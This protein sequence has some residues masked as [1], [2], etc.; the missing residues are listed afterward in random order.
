MLYNKD[1]IINKRSIIYFLI[2]STLAIALNYFAIT[3]FLGIYIFFGSIA[4]FL[5]MDIYGVTPAIFISILASLHNYTLL[6]RWDS[7]IIFPLEILIVFLLQKRNKYLIVSDLIFWIFVGVPISVIFSK[8]VFNTESYHATIIS[9]KAIINGILNSFFASIILTHFQLEKKITKYT[10]NTLIPVSRIFFNIVVGCILIPSIILVIII[11]RI[12]LTDT[13]KDLEYKINKRSEFIITKSININSLYE[14]I[15]TDYFGNNQSVV[16]A[17]DNYKVISVGNPNRNFSVKYT[18]SGYKEANIHLG[19]Y[20][21]LLYPTYKNLS[22]M[23]KLKYSLVVKELKL[24]IDNTRFRVI[25]ETPIKPYYEQME[26]FFIQTLSIITLLIIIGLVLALI[27]SDALTKPIKELTITTANLP[28]K[29]FN[30]EI[31]NWN[32]SLVHE[33]TTLIENFKIT[34]DK[35][36]EKFN[37]VNIA[38]HALETMAYEDP[39]TKLPNRIAFNDKFNEVAASDNETFGVMLLDLNRF[40]IVNDTLGHHFGDELLRLV[41]MRINLAIGSLGIL[42]RM[43]GDEFT[44]LVP[45]ISEESDLAIIAD[46][47]ITALS[48]PFVFKNKEFYIG[49]SIGISVYPRDGENYA[50]LVRNADMAMYRAKLNSGL[51]SYKF[52]NSSMNDEL[53]ENLKLESSLRQAVKNNEFILYYQPQQSLNTESIIGMEALLRWN[54]PRFGIIPPSK[55]IPILEETGLIIEVGEW[56]IR[57]ACIQN[58]LLQDMGVKP[59][60]VAVNLSVKQFLDINFAYKVQKILEETGL[61][62]KWL[63]LEITESIAVQDV[64]LTINILNK[65]HSMGVSISLDDFGTGFSSLQYLKHFKIN[66]LKIDACFIRDMVRDEDSKSIVDTVI[67]L[68]KNLKLKVIAEGVET[69]EQWALLKKQKCDEIQGYYYSKPLPF[70]EVSE[71]L[72]VIDNRNLMTAPIIR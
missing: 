59:I 41:S 25:I 2:L 62:S 49:V 6:N 17:D 21:V 70:E 42:S 26:Y 50:S 72:E 36:K 31:I 38:R 23:R 3:S 43:G 45:N 57:E 16:L 55:F 67:S 35:L 48:T 71:F 53:N 60:K 7:L 4:A 40:K 46:Q 39:L 28:N 15:N 29:I 8:L 9:L 52:F 54:S 69:R 63:E 68:A 34:S 19:N 44:V 37:Q 66:T 30:N 20:G 58:K 14:A 32:S 27:A 61:D 11:Y 1:L 33:Y 64:A 65:L 22:P 51:S 18:I 56:A 24:T 47:I 13:I 5:I 10:K 12:K